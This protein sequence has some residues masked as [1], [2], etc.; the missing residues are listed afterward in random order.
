MENTMGQVKQQNKP[1]RELKSPDV[2]SYINS[3]W[4]SIYVKNWME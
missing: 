2:C 1:D 4:F 3:T